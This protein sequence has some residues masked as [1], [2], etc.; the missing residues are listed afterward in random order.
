M[1]KSVEVTGLPRHEKSLAF[2]LN[3]DLNIITGRNG[4]G[5]TT[6]LKLIWYIIS[7]NISL[8]IR[9]VPFQRARIVTSDYDIVINRASSNQCKIEFSRADDK[10]FFEDVLDDDNDVIIDAEELANDA[11]K[12]IGSSVFFPTFR[13]IEGGFSLGTQTVTPSLRPTMRQRTDIE[14]ALIALSARLTNERHTF[15]AAMST[16]DIVNLLMRNYTELSEISNNLQ[17]TTSQE[18]I[19]KIKN[20]QRDSN[21]DKLSLASRAENVID[22]I[23]LMIERMDKER[24]TIMI[25]LDAVREVVERLFQHSGIKLGARLSFGDAATA[26]NSDLLS[27]GEKQMLSFICYNAFYKNSVI[28]VDEPE[29]SL[30][31]DWQRQLFPI[32]Q[33]QGTSNQFIIATHSPFIY[34]KFPEKEIL[35]G[36]DRGSAEDID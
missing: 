4:S 25:P 5:K 26:V 18:V 34:S 30:H 31:V 6:L 9:E 32:L 2:D 27:A 14:Q 16:F 11:I 3:E 20:Y 13:R 21:V 28:F 33:D 35:L 23:R 17:R 19:D 29:L 15:V 36:S 1:I 7:G 24:D 12:G 8:A 10:N 22:N